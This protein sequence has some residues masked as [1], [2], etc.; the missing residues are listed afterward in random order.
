ME[1]GKIIVN[2]YPDKNIKLFYV[3]NSLITILV[4]FDRKTLFLMKSA[5]L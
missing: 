2:L 5:A 3:H 1:A 4:I